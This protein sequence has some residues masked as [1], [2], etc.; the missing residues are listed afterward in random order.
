MGIFLT[1]NERSQLKTAYKRS[2]NV[3][4]SRKAHVILLLAKGLSYAE[5][6]ELCFVD[7]I[8]IRRYELSYKSGGLSS[9]SEMKFKGSD[10]SLSKF[11]QAELKEHLSQIIYPN[12]KAVCKMVEKKY[13]VR[14]SER[15]MVKL[16]KRLGF[17]YKK[18]QIVPGKANPKAQKEFIEKYKILEK[19][20]GPKDKIL[21]MDGVHPHHN[22]KPAYGW[23]LKGKTVHLKSN[24]GRKRININGVISPDGSQGIFK[25]YE[26]IDANSTIDLLKT[27]ENKNP[28]AKK[29]YVVCDNARYYRAQKVSEFLKTSKIKLVFLPPYSPNINSIER[30]WKFYHEKITNNRYYEKFD[31]FRNATMGFF[32]QLDSY[33]QELSRRLKNN[34]Q[35]IDSSQNLAAA[36]QI[37]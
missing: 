23:I 14:Y 30:V 8:T 27:V 13:D 6:A 20:L 28:D 26:T 24:T 17:V 19:G 33:Q 31:D 35:I 21:F 3:N 16:L 4:V 11:Q 2:K 1:H 32:N 7:E 22:S 9:I 34:F 5:V 29:V 37:I 15:G 36:P 10:C 12:A 18:P 25:E